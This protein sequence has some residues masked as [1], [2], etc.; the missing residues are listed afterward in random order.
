[1]LLKIQINND[2]KNCDTKRTFQPFQ[3]PFKNHR[4]QLTVQKS[5][6]RVANQLCA[7]CE[8]HGV[9]DGKSCELHP[10]YKDIKLDDDCILGN[11]VKDMI[12][13]TNLKP[14]AIE[15]AKPYSTN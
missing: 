11:N 3:P 9:F 2:W 6:F 12:R 1:M 15:P 14:L 4:L 10:L 13:L 5:D 8:N 7:H